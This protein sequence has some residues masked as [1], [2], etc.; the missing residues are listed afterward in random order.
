MEA[1]RYHKFLRV[2][3]IVFAI[4]IVFDGGFLTPVSKQLS[5]STIAYL[6]SSVTGVYATIAPNELN[7]LTAQ[8]SQRERELDAREAA[9]NERVISTRDF[10]TSGTID[11]STY[12]LGLILLLLTALIML[13]Y[14]LDWVRVRNE[15]H[16]QPIS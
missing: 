13:N 11:Y 8:I 9:L 7:H 2:S 16:A 5:D 12:I 10:G 4:L 14:V 15:R 6:A 1:S 3:A